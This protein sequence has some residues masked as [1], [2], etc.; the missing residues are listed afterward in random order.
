MKITLILLGLLSGIDLSAQLI[1]SSPDMPSAGDTNRMSI[2]Y[3]TFAF[4]F[5]QSGEDY[6][7][8]F[9]GLKPLAQRVDSFVGP[10]ETPGIYQFIFVPFFVTN[11]A[12][13]VSELSAIPGIEL[14]NVFLYYKN[15]DNGYKDVGFAA[16]LMGI[17]LPVKYTNPDVYYHFPMEYQNLDSSNATYMVDI[18]GLAHAEGYRKRV[19]QVDGRGTLHTPFGSFNTLRLKSEV[20]R[21]DSLYLDTLGTGVPVYRN[22]TEYK[23]L[24]KGMGQP[25]LEV[26]IEGLLITAIYR[27]S[28]RDVFMGIQEK[29]D[30]E[31][32]K[33]FPN[34]S[35]QILHLDFT[36]KEET[37]LAISLT[38]LSGRIISLYPTE[39]YVAGKYSKRIY[40]P[41]NLSSGAY[42]LGIGKGN[43]FL[44]KKVLIK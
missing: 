42:L 1:I 39:R 7:W 23:W 38:G 24:A 37:E 12:Q 18:P 11:L 13:P 19:N 25:L 44:Q 15:E 16:T 17:P 33:V 3:N 40:L 21:F 14:D 2:A 36:V 8:D 22:Y 43:K 32:M 6:V 26:R 34:P 30:V 27:D 9:S 10:T 31:E 41:E 29:P 5:E 20:N 4:D 35:S 28:V